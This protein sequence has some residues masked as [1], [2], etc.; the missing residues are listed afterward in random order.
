[1]LLDFLRRELV[2]K[3]DYLNTAYQESL[4]QQSSQHL[5]DP[6]A[7]RWQIGRWLNDIREIIAVAND[8]KNHGINPTPT[9]IHRADFVPIVI[10][11]RSCV[12][13]QQQGDYQAISGITTAV[14]L[15]NSAAMST[16]LRAGKC[17][18]IDPAIES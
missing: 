18:W 2:I 3:V 12:I 10:Y 5:I 8:S 7:Q 13:R 11:S 6:W 15:A 17:V 1:M 4:L 9:R 14:G 16:S